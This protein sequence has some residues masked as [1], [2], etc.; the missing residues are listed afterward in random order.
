[1]DKGKD[2]LVRR[3]PRLGGPVSFQY[4]RTCGDNDLPCW[5]TFDCWWEYFDVVAY[6]KKNL[7]EDTFN[8]LAATKAKPKV[9]S[10]VELIE[11]AKKRAASG[12]K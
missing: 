10:L 12:D 4:C 11:Q 2:H 3:C 6:L 9:T 8:R 1:M 5:K 7:D